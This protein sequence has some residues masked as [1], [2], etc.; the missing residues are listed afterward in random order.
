MKI[1]VEI[2]VTAEEMKTL[3]DLLKPNSRADDLTESLWFGKKVKLKPDISDAGLVDIFGKPEKLSR[4]R[5]YEVVLEKAD[6]ILVEGVVG[7]ISK[8]K[9]ILIK[10]SF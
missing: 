5:E 4:E 3:R 8:N 2:D 10:P 9:F 7:W 1:N 6:A